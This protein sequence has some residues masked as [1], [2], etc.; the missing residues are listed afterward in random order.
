MADILQLDRS[1]ESVRERFNCRTCGAIQAIDAW[2][3]CGHEHDCTRCGTVY[4][5]IG[6]EGSTLDIER[7]VIQ[8]EYSITPGTR[9]VRPMRDAIYSDPVLGP[10]RR[11]QD[12]ARA[13]EQSLGRALADAIDAGMSYRQVAAAA[14]LSKSAVHRIVQAASAHEAGVTASLPPIPV[15]DTDEIV[16]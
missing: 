3:K 7:A 8:R 16:F 14:G 2:A 11:A 6:D 4:A 10:I 12:R 13:A 15:L 9:R 1:S 5:V